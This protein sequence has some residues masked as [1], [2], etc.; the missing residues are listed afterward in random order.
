MIAFGRHI[1]VMASS[2]KAAVADSLEGLSI[3]F[4]FS[5]CAELFFLSLRENVA[6]SRQPSKS[7]A[8]S[9]NILNGDESSK[10]DF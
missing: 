1:S 5:S 6:Y 8:T 10:S 2:K 4:H 9:V 7:A 3:I